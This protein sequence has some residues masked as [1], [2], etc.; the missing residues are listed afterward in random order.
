M[1]KKLHYLVVLGFFSI[2][3]LQAQTAPDKCALEI[4]EQ[5]I[6][7]LGGKSR[8]SAI[9]NLQISGY[10]YKNAIE[11][12]ERFEG[13]YIPVNFNFK[14]VLDFKDTLEQYEEEQKFV[15]YSFGRKYLLDKNCVALKLPKGSFFP[16]AQNQSMQDDLYL[17]PLN[18]LDKAINSSSLVCL[19]DTMIHGILNKRIKFL[20]NNYPVIISINQ[21]TNLF[22][23]VEIRKPYSN[24]YF[25]TWGDLNKVIY[26][27]AWDLLENGVH[28]PRQKDIYFLG[29]LWETSMIMEFVIN[30]PFS[31]DSVR[32]PADIQQASMDFW[33]S[34]SS[35]IK[36]TMERKKEIAKD[37]WLIPGPCN[38]TVVKQNNELVIIESPN[39]SSNTDQIIE[40]AKKIFPGTSL[41]YIVTTSDA[42]LHCGGVRSAAAN[43]TVVALSANKQIIESLLKADFKTE[44]DIWQNM[45]IKKPKIK[46]VD[47]PTELG[48]G[49]NRIKLIPFRTETGERM[50]MVYFPEY[51]LLYASDLL[52]PSGFI[53]H[54]NW[55]VIQAVKREKLE[56]EKIYS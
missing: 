43:A 13:P 38:S 37:I 49:T 27:S 39:T 15:I 2:L 11:Q 54:Y 53:E 7:A 31:A 10:G 47:M 46:Y 41:N 6:K 4:A 34:N 8:I 23:C 19:K 14:S 21:N 25:N 40:E 35:Q 45:K 51:K 16:L 24:D 3:K 26:Y 12:S 50:M 55:E 1:M 52:Q 56:V 44:P 30:T 18:I 32:I 5:S 9:N 42:W 29:R 33:K 20:W 17:N 36:K 22:T 28:Y 48:V